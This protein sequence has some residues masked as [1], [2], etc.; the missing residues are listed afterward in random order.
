MNSCLAAP[1]PNRNKV[2]ELRNDW[3]AI[4]R[5]EKRKRAMELLHEGYS[6]RGLAK[7]L[8]ISEATLRY[9]LNTKHE[10]STSSTLNAAALSGSSGNVAKDLS[11]GTAS[12]ALTPPAT[13]ATKTGTSGDL[14]EL[15]NDADVEGLQKQ[16]AVRRQEEV[17]TAWINNLILAFAGFL[18]QNWS[19][20]PEACLQVLPLI[21]TRLNE[22]EL[23]RDLPQPLPAGTNARRVLAA[24]HADPKTQDYEQVIFRAVVGLLY[25]AE[26]PDLRRRILRGLTQLFRSDLQVAERLLR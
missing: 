1:E 3:D 21:A 14:M 9:Y 10:R 12:S 2:E 26:N 5:E 11:P 7:A 16:A 24:I 17:L 23:S 18:A 4:S 22:A 6:K 19:L 13:A 15:F 20:E 25:L 8:N